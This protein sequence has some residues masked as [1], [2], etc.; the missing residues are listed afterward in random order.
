MRFPGKK[1]TRLW[2]P[3]Q[4]CVDPEKAAEIRAR[5][6]RSSRKLEDQLRYLILLGLEREDELQRHEQKLTFHR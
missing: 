6:E 3:K 5:A 1:T 4:L 2:L